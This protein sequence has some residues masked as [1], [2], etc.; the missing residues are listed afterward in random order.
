MLIPALIVQLFILINPLS[1]FPMLMGAYRKRMD[2]K[3]IAIYSVIIAFAIAILFVF[4]GPLFFAM[5][6]ISLN[7]LMIAGGIILVL[8]GIDT[9][10]LNEEYGKNANEMD[11]YISLIA[12]PMLTGPAT[13]SFIILKSYEIGAIDLVANITAT[14]MV[15]GIVFLCTAAMIRKVNA[16]AI[17]IVS[18]IFGLFLTAIGIEMIAKGIQ[19]L[20]I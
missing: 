9:V 15:I 2:V 10:R 6:G 1:S 7:S 11:G 20:L 4:V 13:I 17:S 3:K 18:K 5:F 12:S 16:R 19:A 14:F 8:L